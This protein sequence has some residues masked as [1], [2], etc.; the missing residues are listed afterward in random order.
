[1]CNVI[2]CMQSLALHSERVKKLEQLQLLETFQKLEMPV[3]LV[4]ARMEY[5]GVGFAKENVDL[6]TRVVMLKVQCSS[7][8]TECAHA[9]E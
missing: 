2:Q 6:A 1:M 3:T 8:L 9:S 4:L 5:E 7:C